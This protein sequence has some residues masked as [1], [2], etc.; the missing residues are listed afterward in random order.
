M[1]IPSS[2]AQ[3]NMDATSQYQPISQTNMASFPA[4]GQPWLSGSQSIKSVTPVHQTGEQILVAATVSATFMQPNGFKPIEKVPSEW[5]EHT[6]REGK[7]YYY[8][9]KTKLSSWEKPL[10]LMTAIE[11]AD[12]S[13][14]W[15]EVTSP[16]GRKYYYNRVTKQSKWMIPDELKLVREQVKIECLKETQE[17]S[18]IVNI[19]APPAVSFTEVKAPPLI[20]NGLSWAHAVV[21]SPVP[22]EPVVAV[23]NPGPVATSGSSP[24]P[25]ESPSV[26]TNTIEA[27][28]HLDTVPPIAAASGTT[29]IS[30]TLINTETPMS[31]SDHFSSKDVVTAAEG[32]SAGNIE[33]I[34]K[35]TSIAGEANINVVEDKTVVQEPIVY[36][37]KL[38]AK[39][40]F[41]ALLETANV[42][43][44]WVWDQAMRLIINDRRYGALKTLGERK[45]AFNEFVGQK[46]KQEAEERRTKQKKAREDFK[47]MLEESK[48]LT[49]STRWSKVIAFFEDDERFKA[50]ER[51][52]DREDL[53]GDYI[54]ELEKKERAKALE[55]HKRNRMEFIEFLRSC[56]FIKANSQWR[57]VQDRLEAD[58]RCS[59]L[60]KI[61]RLEI[62]QEYTRDLEKEE[63]EQRKLQME[64]T[65]K[66]ERKNREEFRK[67]ME[68]HVEAGTL[69]SKTH[70]REYCMKVK[71]LPAYLAVSSNTSGATA[72]D[73]F[74]DVAEELQKQYL[75]DK[76][77]IKDAVKL[78]KI[79]L[80][81]TWTIEDFKAAILEDISSPPV[82]D[83]NL[84]LVFDELQERVKERE[85]KEAKKRKHLADDFYEFLCS[86]KEIT[87]SSRWEDCKPL[88]E[89]RQE[90]WFNGEESFIREIF[91]K[92]I[93]ELKEIAREKERKRREEKAKKDKEGKDR[94][95]RKAKHRRD[96]ERGKEKERPK[97]DETASENGDRAGSYSFEESKRSGRDRNK[98]HRK[99]HP[100]SL[101][102]MGLDEN[103]KDRSK[104]F[105][106]HSTDRKKLKQLEQHSEADYESRSK[107][108][109][110]DHRNGSYRNGDREE[111][112]EREFG[113]D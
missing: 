19:H 29:G 75:E 93:T 41:K 56:D 9:K 4:G 92:Y 25:M 11:K 105:H 2:Y 22:V 107:R 90:N 84:K 55:E 3:I 99:R 10:E 88:F 71:E 104:N 68:G 80:T 52:K 77:R 101:D 1:A 58:E 13:T 95:K 43:S 112:K 70:W 109:K 51:T 89:A 36:E 85:E 24:L 12:A 44:D 61:D 94:E 50:V 21:S 31:N 113:E 16:D 65:R 35:G 82:S 91:E 67:L 72:K 39:H 81:S 106:R 27:Q 38:E 28:T 64:E 7:R 34:K 76:T 60:E 79:T 8:N 20:A 62:F 40:A 48:E 73:L 86:F 5:I 57:K 49:S 102:D 23:V 96:K 78:G 30:A 33:E 17:S 103:D 37:T 26:T 6:S 98:K 110:R 87:A 111:R 97:K 15:R 59:R 69:T 14:D 47:K 83:T 18:N 54:E 32:V 63:E 100:S 45:Q 46:K 108:H 66:A 42:G 53:F 74:E